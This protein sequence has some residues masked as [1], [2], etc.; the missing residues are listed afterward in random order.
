M[1]SQEK[2]L[3]LIAL[4][5][6]AAVGYNSIGE[7]ITRMKLETLAQM[8]QTIE[9]D[10]LARFRQLQDTFA[11]RRVCSEPLLALAV[12]EGRPRFVRLLLEQGASPLR[13][14]LIRTAA[15]AGQTE[16]VELLIAAGAPVNPPVIDPHGPGKEELE[17]LHSHDS[18]TPLHLAAAQG[19]LETVRCLLAHGAQP[20]ALNGHRRT[21]RQQAEFYHQDATA[22]L[23]AEWLNEV[24][25]TVRP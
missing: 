11:G 13:P 1:T 21:P 4:L 7:R 16:I 9:A 10:E 12:D 22:Q 17:W 14:D 2:C 20:N 15:E 24:S 25:L 6:L 8:E 19:H 18:Q 5:L 23:L 3:L